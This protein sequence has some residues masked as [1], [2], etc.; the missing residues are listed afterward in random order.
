MQSHYLKSLEFY[1]QSDSL[2]FVTTLA[3]EL[4]FRIVEMIPRAAAMK[5]RNL[6]HFKVHSYIGTDIAQLREDGERPPRS[7]KM[8]VD[9]DLGSSPGGVIIVSIF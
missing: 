4:S 3:L 8:V 7:A 1:F 2:N 6:Q 9:L 5:S